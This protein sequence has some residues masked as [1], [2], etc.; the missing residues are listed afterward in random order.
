MLLTGSKDH[1][2]FPEIVSVLE[3]A[4]KQS[5]NSKRS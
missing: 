3:G 4:I 1:V 5:E 2:L